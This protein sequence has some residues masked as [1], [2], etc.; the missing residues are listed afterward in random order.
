[1]H[2]AIQ[3]QNINCVTALLADNIVPIDQ[4]LQLNPVKIDVYNDNGLTP[5]HAAI[6][7]NNLCTYKL[8]EEKALA[9]KIPIYERVE[10]KRGDTILHIAVEN[11]AID[12]VRDLLKN[13]KID[14]DKCNASGQTALYLARALDGQSP[15][16]IVQL[17]LQYNAAGT[18]DK[19]NQDGKSGII[20]NCF[21]EQWKK[22]SRIQC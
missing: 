20:P 17:L 13:K 12:I 22:V 5:F 7:T 8:L 14:V 6:E 3:R 1:M 16:N 2:I 21:D 11:G 4:K 9:E 10:L 15:S 18:V 19:E